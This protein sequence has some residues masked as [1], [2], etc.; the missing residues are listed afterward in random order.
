MKRI[1]DDST[2][3]LPAASVKGEVDV[4]ILTIKYEE[5][6]AALKGLTRRRR[7]EGRGA[8]Y[9]LGRVWTLANEELRVAIG[10]T[11]GQGQ[12][13][14]QTLA[15]SMI[16]DLE[17]RW[18]IVVGI[19][20]AYPATEFSLGDVAVSERIHDFSLAA[21]KPDGVREFEDRGRDLAPAAK[22]LVTD[23]IH[24]G[25][26][27]GDWS[28]EAAIGLAKPKVKIPNAKTSDKLEGD[29]SWR[30]SIVEGLKANF[31]AKIPLRAPLAVSATIISSNTLVRDPSLGS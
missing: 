20:G 6:S 10:T 24:F 8:H 1:P 9:S 27:L 14:A 2:D 30:K 12:G 21:E 5:T 31:P 13:P 29:K 17:P 7:V 16:N 19:G 28:T 26:R 23:V 15:S 25:E 22:T 18:L 11:S 3:D 4:A